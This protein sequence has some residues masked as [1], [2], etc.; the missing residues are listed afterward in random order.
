LE[1]PLL[2]PNT[3]TS[4]DGLLDELAVVRAQGFAIDEREVDEDLRCV[5]AAILD[6]HCRPEYAISIAGPATRLTR[7]AAAEIGAA[8]REAAAAISAALGYLAPQAAPA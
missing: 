7:E 2:T 3:I 1:R 8:L 5:G 6:R 4:V